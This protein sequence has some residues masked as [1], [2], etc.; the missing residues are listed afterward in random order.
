MKLEIIK[1]E[2]FRRFENQEFTNKHGYPVPEKTWKFITKVY[3]K[4]RKEGK[5]ER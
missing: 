1:K 4:G 3:E 5:N 2:Y